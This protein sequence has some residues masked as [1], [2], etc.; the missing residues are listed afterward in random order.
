MPDVCR[1]FAHVFIFADDTKLYKHITS[2][3][4]H[5]ALQ[6]ALTALQQWSDRWLLKLNI[7]K[8]KTVFFGRNINTQ[9][10]YSL[11]TTELERLEEIRDLGVIFDSE[12]SFTHHCKEKI[13][14]AY[15]FLGIIK[16]NF[17]YLQEDA[18]VMLY[19]SLVRSHLE[20]A[21]SVWNPYRHGLIK[22]LEKVQMRATKL[23]I[24][25][26]HLKYNERLKK[27]KLPTL[28]YRRLRGDMIEVYKILHNKYDSDTNLSLVKQQDSKT[29]GH[30]LKLVN[31][32]CHYDLRKFSFSCRIV[33]VWNSLPEHIISAEST[34][35]FK[36]RLDKF[37]SKQDLLYDFKAELT[38]I[39]NR[40]L[41]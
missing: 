28:K 41:V 19:K 30:S 7:K 23:V 15:S 13:S 31:I 39:G 1:P 18:F 22:D 27:L 24:S 20:Y 25:I 21:N 2:D 14:T 12:L 17:V 9:Y 37:W 4:D 16:R 10:R 8:C 5:N 40:S 6:Q 11:Q 32:R 34:D 3:E 36:S 29:R 26:K 33:N 38:G 35:T